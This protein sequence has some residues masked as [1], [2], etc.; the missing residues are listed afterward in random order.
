MASC[1]S[2]GNVPNPSRTSAWPPCDTWQRTVSLDSASQ[3]FLRAQRIQRFGHVERGVEQRAVEIE[4]HAFDE[5]A[6]AATVTGRRL[7]CMR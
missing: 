2:G 3:A 5:I 1:S 6:H 4:Q 7:R